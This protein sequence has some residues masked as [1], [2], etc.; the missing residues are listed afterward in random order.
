[1][2]YIRGDSS[3]LRH[4]FCQED[5]LDGELGYRRRTVPD[6]V[7][8]VEAATYENVED[9]QSNRGDDN[10]IFNVCYAVLVTP[11]AHRCCLHWKVRHR[12]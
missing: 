1:M 2:R 10:A 7:W 8:E 5:C 6:R 9:R 11:E 3:T 12:F 4:F